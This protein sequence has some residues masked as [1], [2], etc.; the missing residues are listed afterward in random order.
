[1]GQKWSEYFSRL[2]AFLLPK[3]L[4]KSELTF[5]TVK[6]PAKTTPASV[7]KVT[8]PY[9]AP[10]PADRPMDEPVMTTDQAQVEVQ[11]DQPHSVDFYQLAD[12]PSTNQTPAVPHQLLG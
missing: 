6:R 8:E 12:Q 5:Q 4:E 7:L 10:K 9:I 3:S 1:M 11:R 2:E